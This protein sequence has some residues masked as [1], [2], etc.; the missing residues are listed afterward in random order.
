MY[1]TEKQAQKATIQSADKLF[2]C[3]GRDGAGIEYWYP[4]GT[5]AVRINRSYRRQGARE[6]GCDFIACSPTRSHIYAVELSTGARNC[7]EGD[8][9]IRVMEHKD[10]EC[11][12]KH[13]KRIHEN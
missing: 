12:A 1:A 6:C 8:N 10:F 13:L 4:A 2:Q 11:A 5:R 7:F 3:Y 9:F